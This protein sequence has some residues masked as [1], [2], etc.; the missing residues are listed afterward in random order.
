MA[1]TTTAEEHRDSWAAALRRQDEVPQNA[2]ADH[3]PAL[4]PDWWSSWHDAC[5]TVYGIPPREGPDGKSAD[6]S[7]D[8][9]SQALIHMHNTVNRALA[10]LWGAV[11]ADIE[12]AWLATSI[13]GGLETSDCQEAD[14]CHGDRRGRILA[15]TAPSRRLG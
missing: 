6:P 10:P 2:V 12:T 8:E 9:D 14:L 1:M 15:V 11:I 5:V 3:A 13:G 4:P 7:G